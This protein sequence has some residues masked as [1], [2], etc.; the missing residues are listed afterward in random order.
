[1]KT[2]LQDLYKTRYFQYMGF[3]ILGFDLC[4]G[5]Y[6]IIES[7]GKSLSR[8]LVTGKSA[9]ILTLPESRHNAMELLALMVSSNTAYIAS[10]YM[11]N[12]LM[13]LARP[14]IPRTQVGIA[15]GGVASLS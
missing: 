15:T 3:M 12:V 10:E 14:H 8:I 4:G 6:A 11:I 2:L 5:N 13:A 1:M 7:T 9:L